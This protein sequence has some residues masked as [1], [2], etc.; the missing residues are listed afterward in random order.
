MLVA[1]TLRGFVGGRLST[2]PRDETQL[3]AE[4]EQSVKYFSN[5]ALFSDHYLVERMDAHLEWAEDIGD[6][7]AQLHG[8]Y[9]AKRDIL[10]VLNEAMTEAE[11][12][13]PALEN[14]GFAYIPQ[15]GFTRAGRQLRPDY[16]LFTDEVG[17]TEAYRFLKDEGK[18][19]PRALAI[20]DAKYWG[21][22]LDVKREA[23]PRDE[24]KNTNPSFQIV[25]Y[26]VGTDVDWGILTNG[27][28][29][30]LYY[31]K[32]RSR[33][34]T[35]YEVDLGLILE[36]EDREAFRYFYHFFRQDALVKD[37][38][39]DRNFLERVCEGSA[40]YALQVQQE[41]K[42]LIFERIVPILAEGFVAW[43]RT[44][45]GIAE[46]T[47]PLLR[48]I[49]TA[50]LTLLYRLLFLLYA[51]SRELLPVS[52]RLGYYRYS[53][54]RLKR[55]AMARLGREEVFSTVSDDV[56]NDLAALFRIIDQGDPA[57][58]VPTYNGGLFDRRSPK[59]AFLEE[60]R[61][62]DGYL[63]Q[64]LDLLTRRDNPDTEERRFIDYK[65]LDVRHL[66][67]IYEGLLEFCL[68]I[69]QED[70]AAV[71]ER[72]VEVYKPLSEVK[73]SRRLGVVRKGELYL[74]NDKGQRKATGSYY[75]PDYIVKYIVANTLGPIMDEREAAFAEAVSECEACRKKFKRARSSG[76][77]KLVRDEL[78]TLEQRAVNC[79]L[80]IKVC[81]PAM[82]SGHFL[83]EA[84]AYLTDRIIDILNQHPEN[85]ILKK[86][87]A[88]RREILA[89][90]EE[91]GIRIDPELLTDT[92]LLKR[93]VMKR[94]IYGVDLNPMAVELAKLSLW[95]DSFTVGAPLSFLDHHLKVGNSL[96]GIRDIMQ[97]IAPASQREQE[98]RRAIA[99]TIYISSLTDSTFN[100]VRTSQTLFEECRKLLKPTKERLNVELATNFVDLGKITRA[101]QLAY[102]DIDSRSAADPESLRKFTLA[103]QVAEDKQFFHWELEFPEVFYTVK[104][105]R[106]NPG[107]DVV[108]GNPPYLFL[109]GKG[110]PVR[111]LEKE[112]K[113]SEAEGL[114]REINY[115][116][117]RFAQSS[118]GC[119]DYYKWFIDQCT[120][121]ARSHGRASLIVSNTWIAYPR[122]RDIRTILAI[123]NRL[124][125][126]ID[127]GGEVFPDPTVLA[128]I[129]VVQISKSAR[130]SRRIN[131]AD[132]KRYPRSKLG[133]GDFSEIVQAHRSS[134]P[135]DR[136]IVE[137]EIYRSPVASRLMTGLPDDF[138]ITPFVIHEGEHDLN[139]DRGQLKAHPD[140]D[141]VPVVRD[142][143]MAR[144][145]PPSIAFLPKSVAGVSVHALHQ[146]KRLLLR[147]TGDTIVTAPPLDY[148]DGLA[149]QNVYVV[150]VVDAEIKP[151]Y[152][153]SLLNSRLLTHV[154]QHSPFG[155]AGRVQA[156]FRID[157]LYR[158]PIRRIEFT[159]PERERRTLVEAGQALYWEY[160]D[161]NDWE[162]LLEF[163]DSRLQVITDQD[164]NVLEPEQADV[165]HDLLAYLAEQMIDMHEEK[166]HYLRAFRTDM[167]GLLSATQLKK[168][169]RLYTP[170][171]PP[172]REAKD[173]EKKQAHYEK[174]LTAAQEALGTKLAQEKLE[175]DDFYRLN[176]AQFKWCLKARLKKVTNLSDLVAC[177]QHHR[178][179]LAPLAAN[180]EA[181]DRLIDQIVYKLYRLTD[182]E[183]AIVE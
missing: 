151:E 85:P 167:E 125:E 181:T 170:P 88:I 69:A 76:T 122:F 54:T 90:L 53:L 89:N 109:S 172:K 42:G 86:L 155:Q 48:Q 40:T 80:D 25:N 50:T 94:C 138:S 34:S 127:I 158:L 4:E 182:E 12:I 18:F 152:I 55:E 45:R 124:I 104:G 135:L 168:V 115:L 183:I 51:E 114:R 153:C 72:G 160:L 166:Q 35:Y 100:E 3:P 73:E 47:E 79:L 84:V 136:G 23:D 92:N 129:F 161:T 31:Q 163:V 159:T 66:G 38:A 165:V 176:E 59:N 106:Q 74:K 133:H 41:L 120:R 14:L 17:K 62:A 180:I 128:S 95:L 29:W 16:A 46:E 65:D 119:K 141:D 145:L 140:P 28:L 13:R 91:Q 103:Q 67:S 139:I 131:Y 113:Y 5:Q 1:I 121:L 57:L 156:Q 43:R 30:R 98:L 179:I 143:E 117:E 147:K 56:W 118:E 112:G 44:E 126:L 27:R 164:G 162:R 173:F 87:A 177:F 157:F 107:F 32:A 171:R 70:L 9:H 169:S 174:T 11:F 78:A 52:D 2:E 26:L 21:R 7:F 63:V 83:V 93:M 149:H 60:H 82:G 96:I 146:G 178:V 37:P 75:T 142:W 10:D 64:A 154:Y 137:F 77:I 22:P 110:S 105:H 8:L 58:N 97:Y 81:D 33:A 6:A 134:I 19:Y 71:K 68:R 108:V 123:D 102:S 24:F 116:S 36:R 150:R 99:N 15:T 175:L 49:F 130:G 144:Y 111:R 148:R 61:I 39:T 132:L 101:A 20:C